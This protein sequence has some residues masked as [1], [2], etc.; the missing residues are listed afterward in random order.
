MAPSAARPDVQPGPTAPAATVQA[1]RLRWLHGEVAAIVDQTP[2]VRSLFLTVPDWPGHRAGQH[3]DVRLT[4]EDG[5]QAQRSY[6]IAS[7]PESPRLELAV[8]RLETGE[9]SPYLAGEVRVGDAL[10]LRGPIG[11]YFVWDVAESGPLLLVAGGSGVAP[12]MAMVR[13]RALAGNAAGGRTPT[14]LV[15]SSRSYDEIL[16]R[17]ELDRLAA[18]DPMLHVV[19][20]LTRAQPSGW[21]GHGRRIDAA[22]LAEVAGPPAPGTT[23]FVCGPTRLVES[24]ATDLLALGYPANRV[25]TERFGPSGP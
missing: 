13:H 14:T 9:V 16:F 1:G 15:Y 2:R 11:G 22:L 21:T 3:L 19:H 5:Y 20:T 8:E 12:L 7:P 17:D 24:V 10:E 6:S 23:A 4:A 18:A 25:K